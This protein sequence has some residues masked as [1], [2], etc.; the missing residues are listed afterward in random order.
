MQVENVC[1]LNVETAS[2][3]RSLERWFYNVTSNQ[4]EKI[5]YG[6][7]GGGGNNFKS[8]EECQSFCMTVR[9]RITLESVGCDLTRSSKIN[10]C[11]QMEC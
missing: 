2:C 5:T 6:K 11:L 8:L 10:F 9:G 7:C 3:K 4:C 1:E